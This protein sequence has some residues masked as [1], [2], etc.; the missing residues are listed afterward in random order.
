MPNSTT[1]F[2]P[3]YAGVNYVGDV[4]GS[5]ADASSLGDLAAVHANAVA[6]TA[7]FGIDAVSNTVYQ[8]DVA[9]GYTESNADIAAAISQAVHDGLSVM[10]R[11]LID[12]LPDNFDIDPRSDGCE[13]EERVLLRR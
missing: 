13:P 7:D 8:N 10:V 2:H 9:G 12:F 6:I 11:P 5:F 4:D 1:G 3:L